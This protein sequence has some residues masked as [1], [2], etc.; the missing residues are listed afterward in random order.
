MHIFSK[1]KSF[2]DYQGPVVQSI[3]SLTKALVKDSLSIT[4]LI[5]SNLVTYFANKIV[6]T[7]CT[8]KANNVVSFKQLGPLASLVP[9][10]QNYP[11][12]EG[13]QT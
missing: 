3:V 5:K 10:F 9:K 8:A 7:F 4:V 6:R 13:K 2:H 1:K 12:G 11:N